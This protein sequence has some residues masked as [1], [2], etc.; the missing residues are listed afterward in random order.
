MAPTAVE[1]YLT[2]I[3]CPGHNGIDSADGTCG[4][5]KS[6]DGD[7]GGVE[8]L[9]IPEEREE[10]E[11]QLKRNDGISPTVDAG[12]TIQESTCYDLYSSVHHVGATLGHQWWCYNDSVVVPVTKTSEIASPSAYVLFYI[13]R[14]VR[15]LHVHDIHESPGSEISE[16]ESSS[17]DVQSLRVHTHNMDI[18]DNGMET[19][20]SVGIESRDSSLKPDVYNGA[21]RSAD[22]CILS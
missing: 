17:G 11:E 5:E 13:R 10:M 12:K 22:Q 9:V 21:Y 16:G 15:N 4:G 19:Q 14:D 8:D 20:S 3:H 7:D 18:R 1:Q 2:D 6:G